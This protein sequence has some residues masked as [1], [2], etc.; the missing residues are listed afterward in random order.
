MT[1]CQLYLSCAAQW[2]RPAPGQ[3]A[4]T[5][6]EVTVNYL[7]SA[8]QDWL[9]LSATI[10]RRGPKLAE[11]LTE[12]A[13]VSSAAA[14]VLRA[15]GIADADLILHT[16]RVTQHRP[17]PVFPD[18]ATSVPTPAPDGFD[19]SRRSASACVIPP[20]RRWSWRRWRALG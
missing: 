20:S 3:V 9:A 10:Q 13:G 17:D 14:T 5:V 1:A 16:A 7:A 12:T 19:V 2:D 18:G 4:S 8:P 11:L 6:Q 15:K